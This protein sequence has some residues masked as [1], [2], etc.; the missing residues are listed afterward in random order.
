MWD[1]CMPCHVLHSRITNGCLL[2]HKLSTS[3]IKYLAFGGAWR[4]PSFTS[5]SLIIEKFLKCG[6]LLV[7][8]TKIGYLALIDGILSLF[9]ELVAQIPMK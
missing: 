8:D 4:G 2:F 5:S 1:K 6:I 7:L 3:V 9:S